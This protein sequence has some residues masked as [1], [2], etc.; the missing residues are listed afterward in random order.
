MSK[1]KRFISHQH[2]TYLKKLKVSKRALKIIGQK[3]NDTITDVVIRTLERRTI[4]N[5]LGILTSRLNPDSTHWEWFV[6][7]IMCGVR[8]YLQNNAV[9]VHNLCFDDQL[10][11]DVYEKEL[12]HWKSRQKLFSAQRHQ[13]FRQAF[14]CLTHKIPVS[15]NNN[16][17]TDIKCSGITLDNNPDLSF[18]IPL[19]NDF[20]QFWL[21]SPLRSLGEIV[22]Y[23]EVV[24]REM[25]FFVPLDVASICASYCHHF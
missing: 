24:E 9:F 6:S 1:R 25:Q 14:Y 3:K 21:P 4:L 23:A 12:V 22:K 18:H 15:K 13:R 10:M 8:G 7:S 19:E 2:Q 11:S 16:F 17:I 5:N 20:H